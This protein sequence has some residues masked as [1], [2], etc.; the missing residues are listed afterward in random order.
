MSSFISMYDAFR[1]RLT[2]SKTRTD[3]IPTKSKKS[4]LSRYK[5]FFEDYECKRFH[6]AFRK[7]RKMDLTTKA[8]ATRRKGM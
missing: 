4:M 1:A 8:I 2:R 3:K 5:L 6:G 7:L